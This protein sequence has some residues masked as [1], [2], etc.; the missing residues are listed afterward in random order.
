M[1][2]RDGLPGLTTRRLAREAGVNHG[3][4]HYHFGSLDAVLVAVMDTAGGSWLVSLAHAAQTSG[5][6]LA[7]FRALRAQQDEQITNGQAKLRAELA[8]AAANDP[9]L[10]ERW[11]P[12][13]AARLE[14]L[15]ELV[16]GMLEEYGLSPS[17]SVPATA[18]ISALLYGLEANGL[19]GIE[20]G[21]GEL[22]RW[23]EGWL[24]ALSDGA[25]PG[26]APGVRPG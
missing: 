17:L 12:F 22:D 3:L 23:I 16:A 19:S 21:R 5:G 25:Q 6:F 8:L 14:L 2:I 7:S 9:Q 4:V 1:F 13:L 24:L 15:S 26:P 20:A 18:L 11:A 10:G